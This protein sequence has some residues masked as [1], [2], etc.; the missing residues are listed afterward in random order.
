[1]INANKAYSI[2]DKEE[3][4]VAKPGEGKYSFQIGG[5]YLDLSNNII[6]GESS[7]AS[8]IRNII[9]GN[10]SLSAGKENYSIGQHNFSLGQR[11]IS[12]NE[13]EIVLGAY[14]KINPVV[15][16]QE[17]DQIL[18]SDLTLSF[19]YSDE[20]F[21]RRDTS[22]MR[23]NYEPYTEMKNPKMFTPYD[24]NLSIEEIYL[25]LAGK[26]IQLQP[27]I[28]EEIYK[29]SITPKFKYITAEDG[30]QS[31][32]MYDLILGRHKIS[33]SDNKTI[34]TIGNGT[35]E[36]NRSN[37][38]TIDLY[39]NAEVSNDLIINGNNHLKG[40]LIV[41][42]NAEISNIYTTN[43]YVNGYTDLKGNVDIRE[44]LTI[45]NNLNINNELI[46]EG[47]T[48]FTKIPIVINEETG[49][50]DPLVVTS[51]LNETKDE[52]MDEVSSIASSITTQIW[53]SGSI[54]PTDSKL[55]WIK[56]G[57]DFGNGVIYYFDSTKYSEDTST[58]I[59]CISYKNSMKIEYSDSFTTNGGMF[60]LNNP[61]KYTITTDNLESE[62]QNLLVGKYV[63]VDNY[64]LKIT[65]LDFI[66]S[67]M[68]DEME[69]IPVFGIYG[70]KTSF[71]TSEANW[72]PMS[73]VYY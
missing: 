70:Y 23:D 18:Y 10:Y 1:M 34:F 35:S 53:H 42:G 5:N 68:P 33:L 47:D 66:V 69:Q 60:I 8:G 26:Y 24:T 13:N 45:H 27:Y 44:N 3:D 21:V 25:E 62:A 56:I 43:L 16:D 71:D 31:Q 40:D 61:I 58:T 39:G 64:L 6:T 46:V 59:E 19:L 12:A 29:I 49:E 7:L 37:A 28:E 65:T 63:K 57:T 22:F 55:L 15:E 4:I 41:D 30:T 14:N 17:F 51:V 54:P 36:D 73:A 32:I 67:L 50:S 38:F 20:I 48:H 11:L 9:L 52:I 72:I 2:R